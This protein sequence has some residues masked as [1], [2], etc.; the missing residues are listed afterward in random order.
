MLRSWPWLT[1]LRALRRRFR[2]DRLAVTAGSLTFT[3]L[4]A[5]VP[6][7]TVMLAVFTAFP[8]FSGFEASL[9]KYFL[10]HLVP[11]NIAR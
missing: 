5:L 6:L 7:L 3:T 1:T 8:M 4:I 9:N 11:D 10:Q 2:E